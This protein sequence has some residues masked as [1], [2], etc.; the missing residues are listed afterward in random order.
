[1]F[2]VWVSSFARS[3]GCLPSPLS[4]GF[5]WVPPVGGARERKQSRRREQTKRRAGGFVWAR[6]RRAPSRTRQEAL[7]AA[8]GLH[9]CWFSR[10]TPALCK[11]LIY[12]AVFTPLNIH[13]VSKSSVS[14]WDQDWCKVRTPCKRLDAW[15]HWSEWSWRE[16]GKRKNSKTGREEAGFDWGCQL[17][18][19]QCR[20]VPLLH[21]VWL[22]ERREFTILFTGQEFIKL[23]K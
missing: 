18:C 9:P 5:Q 16:W 17:C 4:A 13:R 8:A 23:G 6:A 10:T 15:P 7:P 11:Q 19:V 22:S 12:T 14:F 20:R 3:L 1:M 21:L 2:S